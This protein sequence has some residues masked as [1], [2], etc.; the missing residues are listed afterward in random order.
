MLP[1]RITFTNSNLKLHVFTNLR[2]RHMTTTTTTT[3]ITATTTTA[4]T[5]PTMMMTG[6]P[7]SVDTV[8]QT[9]NIYLFKIPQKF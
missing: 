7:G 5:T 2:R 9:N 1:M 4:T 3:M 8:S 6:K